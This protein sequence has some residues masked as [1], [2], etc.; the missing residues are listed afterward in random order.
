MLLPPLLLILLP[1]PLRRSLPEE[2][3]PFSESSEAWAEGEL[4][5]LPF[6]P[7][8]EPFFFSPPSCLAPP[9][10]A[11][12]P[13]ISPPTFFFSLLPRLLPKLPSLL[14]TESALFLSLSLSFSFLLLSFTTVPV[15]PQLD[16]LDEEEELF[17]AKHVPPLTADPVVVSPLPLELL[18]TDSLSDSPESGGVRTSSPADAVGDSGWARGACCR[19]TKQI[20]K[21]HI[22]FRRTST[23]DS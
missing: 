2:G 6:L 19:E 20:H 15:D 14:A 21:N 22:Q 8:N 13:V 3:E 23:Q 11:F 10:P 12:F 18:L 17:L 7:L 5:L 16:E 9:A 4:S 1:V